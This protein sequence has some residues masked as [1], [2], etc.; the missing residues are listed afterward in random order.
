MP[1]FPVL[2]SRCIR[3]FYTLTAFRQDLKMEKQKLGILRP[4]SVHVFQRGRRT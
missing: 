3:I 4:N 2:Y 1:I